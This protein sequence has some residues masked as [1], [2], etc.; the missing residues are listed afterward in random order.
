[1]ALPTNSATMASS[2]QLE[3]ATRGGTSVPPSQLQSS[4]Q[5]TYGAPVTA[6]G[7]APFTQTVTDMSDSQALDVFSL[8]SA[9]DFTANTL[10]SQ[11]HSVE[12]S[13][14]AVAPGNADHVSLQVK[15]WNC[16]RLRS[17]TSFWRLISAWNPSSWRTLRE[18]SS[19]RWSTRYQPAPI[20]FRVPAPQ[21]HPVLPAVPT[22]R[23][24]HRP[25]N[26]EDFMSLRTKLKQFATHPVTRRSAWMAGAGLF[27]ALCSPTP[28][29][30]QMD[31]SVSFLTSSN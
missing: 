16:T 20:W 21:T 17:A 26:R 30:A 22:I 5:T 19:S 11:S 23:V 9:S 27:I 2:S 25:R 3:S 15:R 10:I 28:A 18:R 13:G 14:A 29:R 4:F 8:T 7:A 12:D 1:M 6:T 31:L 24:R